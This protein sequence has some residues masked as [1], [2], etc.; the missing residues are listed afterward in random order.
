MVDWEEGTCGVIKTLKGQRCYHVKM[1]CAIKLVALIEAGLSTGYQSEV[2][3][4]LDKTTRYE[5]IGYIFYIIMLSN[6]CN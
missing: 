5:A 3:R 2:T 1:D 4:S 6:A